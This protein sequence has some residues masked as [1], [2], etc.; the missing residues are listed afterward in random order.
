MPIILSRFSIIITNYIL[1]KL[2]NT[3]MLLYKLFVRYLVV[4]PACVN[5]ALVSMC[6]E[7][8]D[9]D[10]TSETLAG[11]KIKVISKELI[12]HHRPSFLR[13]NNT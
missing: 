7:R 2:D 9:F 10:V 6:M 12:Q 11:C 3:K 1:R 5:T 8:A 4:K 13:N